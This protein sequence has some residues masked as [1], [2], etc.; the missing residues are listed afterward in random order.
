MGL[1][2]SGVVV[3]LLKEAGTR[4]EKEIRTAQEKRRE[5]RKRQNESWC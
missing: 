2:R 1:S 5:E 4:Y 3:R